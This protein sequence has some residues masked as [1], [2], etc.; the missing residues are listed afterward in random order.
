MISLGDEFIDSPD[1][2]AVLRHLRYAKSIS[3][4][5]DIITLTRGKKHKPISYNRKVN[6]MPVHSKNALF[7]VLKAL[8]FSILWCK[9]KKYNLV[10]S[11]DPFGTAIVALWVRF[12]YKTP[13]IIGNHSSFIDNEEWIRERRVFFSILNWVSKRNL[14]R[15]NACRV[16]NYEERDRYVRKLGINKSSVA[17]IST[18]VLLDNFLQRIRVDETNS[19]RENLDIPLSS[20]VFIWVGRPVRVKRIPVLLKAFNLLLKEIPNAK[21]LL[22]GRFDLQ[23]EELRNI[24]KKL[25]L[26]NKSVIWIDKG[27]PFS[28]LP[29]YYQASD[30]YVHSS[31]YEG[32]GKVMV[33]AAASNLPIVSTETSGAKMIIK[34]GKT[35]ILAPIDDYAALSSAMLELARNKN[36]AENMAE[37]GRR[38]VLD[39]FNQDSVIDRL[40]LMWKKVSDAGYKNRAVVADDLFIR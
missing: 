10:Y 27:V 24:A 15:A 11:Q 5:I 36:M 39:L 4:C 28:E 29:L 16:I 12:F 8:F 23:Q 9:G 26:N 14:H 20:T 18:P 19:L 7:V 2:Q 31:N 21:L 30:V 13:V 34:D 37:S 32:F 22:V 40:T 17:V 6:V 25:G 38:R 33:E 3:G 35:G 1:G